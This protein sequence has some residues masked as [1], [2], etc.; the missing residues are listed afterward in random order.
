[1]ASTTPSPRNGQDFAP[2]IDQTRQL[3]IAQLLM[4]L[5]A[6]RPA[7]RRDDETRRRSI[8]AELVLL[9]DAETMSRRMARQGDTSTAITSD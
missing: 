6:I 1:M 9:L 3:R 4:A 8:E 5:A 7:R 2:T